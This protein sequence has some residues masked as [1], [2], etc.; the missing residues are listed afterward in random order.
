MVY[1]YNLHDKWLLGIDHILGVSLHCLVQRLW[2][3]SLPIT[4]RRQ[5]VQ[6]P[7]S[8]GLPLTVS[9]VSLHDSG[10]SS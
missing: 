4:R 1:D 7:A 8:H 9:A 6:L 3:E 2:V 10:L 5:T